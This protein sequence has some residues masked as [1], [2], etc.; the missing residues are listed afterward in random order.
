MIVISKCDIMQCKESLTAK[1]PEI[2]TSLSSGA[3]VQLQRMRDGTLK[4]WEVRKREIKLET[5]E[6]VKYTL[7]EPAKKEQGR[8]LN[9]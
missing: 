5:G 8:M 4:A 1:L 2:A 9:T 6:S 3:T 7:E